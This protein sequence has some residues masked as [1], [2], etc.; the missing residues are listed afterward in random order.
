MVP[1]L[2]WRACVTRGPDMAVCT[3]SSRP[4][5]VATRDRAMFNREVGMKA[6]DD[7]ADI[8]TEIEKRRKQ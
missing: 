8:I 5:K 1:I 3:R 4:L 7:F 6:V 2:L